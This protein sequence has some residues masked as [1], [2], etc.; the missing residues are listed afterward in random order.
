MTNSIANPGTILPQSFEK[1]QGLIIMAPTILVVGSTGNTGKSVVH[2]LPE[3]LRNSK[4]MS[5]HRIL[6][7]TRNLESHAAQ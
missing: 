2:T 3:L 4:T 1:F 6:G 5:D 7:L